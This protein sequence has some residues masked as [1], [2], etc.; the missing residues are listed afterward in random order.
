[1]WP[2]RRKPKAKPV[3][4][5]QAA[6]PEGPKLKPQRGYTHRCGRCGKWFHDDIEYCAHSCPKR[7]GLTPKQNLDDRRH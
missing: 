1:M 2:F 6:I 4:S 3:E 7:F 5:P